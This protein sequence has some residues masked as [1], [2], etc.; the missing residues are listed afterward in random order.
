M[1]CHR[2][3]CCYSTN[4]LCH[5]R[6][7]SGDVSHPFVGGVEIR[8]SHVVAA[9]MDGVVIG[10]FGHHSPSRAIE[11]QIIFFG[12]D[13]SI[14]I[15][16]F[17]VVRPGGRCGSPASQLAI[18]HIDVIISPVVTIAVLVNGTDVGTGPHPIGHGAG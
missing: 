12:A 18:I 11:I 9:A 3:G 1:M 4:E 2:S 6:V 17:G 8:V 13:R 15:A 10:I 16:V 5:P 7:V 14:K